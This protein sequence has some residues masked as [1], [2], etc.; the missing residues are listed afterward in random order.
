[1]KECNYRPNGQVQGDTKDLPDRGVS[2]GVTDTYGGDLKQGFNN[3]GG[4]GSDT[5]SDPA[6][7]D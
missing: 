2:T 6:T 1:M 4:I 7:G 3:H 5:K